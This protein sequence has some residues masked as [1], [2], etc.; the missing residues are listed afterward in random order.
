[1][2]PL[3]IELR[4]DVYKTSSLPL[5]YAS[6]HYPKCRHIKILTPRIGLGF[7][8]YQSGV[9]PLNYASIQQNNIVC[10]S[11]FKMQVKGIEPPIFFQTNV[12][13]LNDTSTYNLTIVNLTSWI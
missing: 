4:Y 5:T 13:P 10:I 12:L 7:S 8:L 6:I 1:M 9:L 2:L 3:R 11:L